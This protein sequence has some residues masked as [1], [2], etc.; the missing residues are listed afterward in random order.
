MVVAL[1][2]WPSE[3]TFFYFLSLAL[4]SIPR[5]FTRVHLLRSKQLARKTGKGQL[6]VTTY[7]VVTFN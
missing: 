7:D 6:V 5:S 1:I 3:R 4:S 2:D